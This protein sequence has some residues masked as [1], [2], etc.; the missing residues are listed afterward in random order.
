MDLAI[1]QRPDLCI[2][3][4]GLRSAAIGFL[5]PQST[6]VLEEI[7]GADLVRKAPGV[8]EVQLADPGK[9]VKAA[10]SNNEYL[11]HVMAA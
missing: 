3:D 10:G 5:V 8:L 11:G 2:R 1:G 6:G 7:A 4:T 9:P